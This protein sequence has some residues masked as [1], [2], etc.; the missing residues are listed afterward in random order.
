MPSTLLV[1]KARSRL[2]RYMILLLQQ[3]VADC[4]LENPKEYALHLSGAWA[5]FRS[6]HA[7]SSSGNGN[8]FITH[9]T[10][11]VQ[12]TYSGSWRSPNGRRGT[13][14]RQN[15]GLSDGDE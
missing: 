7:I 1:W 4:Q 10:T 2:L 6:I 12:R 5:I 11:S 9:D 3:A 14:A 8:D 13:S 15:S